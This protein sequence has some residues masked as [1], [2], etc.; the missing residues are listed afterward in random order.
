MMEYRTFPET[1]FEYTASP[2]P[3][4]AGTRLNAGRG[5]KTETISI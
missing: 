4:L 1:D 5:R 3:A 2:M